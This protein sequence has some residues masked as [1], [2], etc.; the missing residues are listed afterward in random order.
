MKIYKL[1]FNVIDVNTY[2]LADD[3][4]AG[5]LIDCG[6]NNRQEKSILENF[7]T[8]KKINP[9]LL[10]N[11]HCHLDHIFGNKFM[12]EKYGL[13][14]L[15]G[16]EDEL[17]RRSAVE[18][19]LLFGI[20]MEEPPLPAAFLSDK[21]EIFFGTEKL[22]ALH[23]PGHSAGSFAFYSEANNCVF[24][25]DALFAGSIGRTDLIGGNFETLI[26]SITNKL[27]T[28]PAT[29]VVYAG[30][31]DETTIGREMKTNPFFT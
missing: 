30:H 21:Q 16:E 13:K 4:G 14:T 3:S 7:L 10:L 2:I 12:L 9:V 18:H 17:N 22:V 1:V 15:A 6:C 26:S 11:T 24:T 20:T 23:V 28:L 31:G 8:E 5:A 19:S 29:T 25:G 27:F